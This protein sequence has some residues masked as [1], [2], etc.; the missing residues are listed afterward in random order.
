LNAPSYEAAQRME[1]KLNVPVGPESWEA[2][3]WI[4]PPIEKML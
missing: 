2:P 3:T 4:A 1:P